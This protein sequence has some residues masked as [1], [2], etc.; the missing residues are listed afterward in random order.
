MTE[1][2]KRPEFYSGISW[3][4]IAPDQAR[5]LPQGRL[6]WA[7]YLI[8]TYF[9]AIGLFKFWLVWSAGQGVG[10]ALVN[11]LWPILTG[12]GLLFRVPW[13]IVMAVISATLT[14]WFMFR[15]AISGGT[16]GGAIFALCD[17]I[18]NVGILFYLVEADRPNLIY[19][20]R[21]RKYSEV[22]AGGPEH[23]NPGGENQQPSRA[24][25]R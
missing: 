24:H 8:A 13:A 9:I 4:Y 7:L 6:N 11:G 5:S 17:T 15:G 2:S 18:L 19:R 20:H 25:E 16:D 12:L 14:I 3:V 23:G 1:H 21:F 22:A 10:L